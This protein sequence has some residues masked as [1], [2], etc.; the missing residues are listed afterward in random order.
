MHAAHSAEEAEVLVQSWTPRV[1]PD[2]VHS[3]TSCSMQRQLALDVSSFQ[4]H[5]CGESA[6]QTAVFCTPQT[7]TL[8]LQSEVPEHA[9]PPA[10][11]EG[12]AHRA[13]CRLTRVVNALLGAALHET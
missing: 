12:L 3:R 10:L 11:L 5:S 9:R 13:K 2:R 4:T 1:P 8:T 6:R 7:G